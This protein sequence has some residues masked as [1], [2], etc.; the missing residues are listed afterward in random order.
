MTINGN[1]IIIDFTNALQ[2]A[3]LTSYDIN[4]CETKLHAKSVMCCFTDIFSDIY[5]LYIRV[6]ISSEPGHFQHVI[7][8]LFPL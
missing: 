2:W 6:S 4:I 8:L 7:L 1:L 5:F 3:L